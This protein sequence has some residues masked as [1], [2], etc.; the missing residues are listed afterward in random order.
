[1]TGR[2]ASGLDL[3]YRDFFSTTLQLTRDVSK[4]EEAYRRMVFNVAVYNT[5][6]H[7]KNHAFIYREGKWTLSPAFDVTFRPGTPGQEAIRAMPVSGM[8]SEVSIAQI[9][10]E[11][12]IAGVGQPRRIAAEVLATVEQVAEVAKALSFDSKPLRAVIKQ[13]QMHAHNLRP[14]RARPT[15]HVKKKIIAKPVGKA[16]K[17]DPIPYLSA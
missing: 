6:D 10:R 7:A 13:I 12:E 14:P 4:V 17:R 1:M 3:D 9:I 8:S 11:G 16:P 2:P 15:K 5:D